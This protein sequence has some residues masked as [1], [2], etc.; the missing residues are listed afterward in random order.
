MKRDL[1]KFIPLLLLY[2]VIVIIF[3]SN[4]FAGDESGYV[5]YANHLINGYQAAPGE[6]R[7][8]WGPG[9]PII[10]APFIFLKIPLLAAKILN[11]VFVF[12]AVLYFYKTVS[13]YFEN[14]H[15]IILTFAMGLYPPML[16]LLNVV[17]T[18][19]L[20]YLLVSGFMFHFC[21]ALRESGAARGHLLAAS[22]YLGYL[23]LTKVFFGYVILAGI[24]LF[25]GL[26]VW[27]R[28]DKTKKTTYI[29]LMA[30]LLCLPYLTYTYSVTGRFFYW[31]SSGGMSLYWMS[32]SYHKNEVGSWFSYANVK[33]TPELATHRDFF[34]KISGL[35]EIEK[36][37]A[38]TRQA[39]TNITHHPVTYFKNWIANN[40]RLLFS[41][42]YSFTEQKISTLFYLIPNMFIVVLLILSV[43]PAILRWR[44]IPYELLALLVFVLI[45][46]GGTSLLSAYDRQ[47]RPLV[48]FFLIWLSFVYIRI[49]KIEL[50]HAPPNTL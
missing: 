43:Y 23:A 17:M 31:G 16:T 28:T 4:K 26:S 32:T 46:Y 39:I 49:L 40:S 7:L 33:D 37:K 42:P 21:R 48:P 35:S 34:D 24:L 38:F 27:Q 10:L 3:S 19:N 12:G 20:V 44:I 25:T 45:T 47:F 22:A 41:F 29:Y 30:L 8:W 15:A 11:A 1:F 5:R 50:P 9:Y 36:N 14:K 13:L 2:L 6:N 18:E